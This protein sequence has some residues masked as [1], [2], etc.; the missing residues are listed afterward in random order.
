MIMSRRL[1]IMAITVMV[2]TILSVCN[3]DHDM[4]DKTIQKRRF[5]R[6]WQLLSIMTIFKY[7]CYQ[8]TLPGYIKCNTY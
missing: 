5:T 7:K 1:I 3:L 6:L 2:Q 4:S 8:I